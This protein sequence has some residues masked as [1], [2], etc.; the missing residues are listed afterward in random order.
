VRSRAQKLKAL[1]AFT[2]LALH[3]VSHAALAQPAQTTP[4]E[5]EMKRALDQVRKDPNLGVSTEIRKLKWAGQNQPRP[6]RD[7]SAFRWLTELARWIA[8]TSRILIYV[9]AGLAVIAL[10]L[11]ITRFLGEREP[12]AAKRRVILPTHVR[13]LDIRPESLPDNI[14]SAARELWDRNEHRAALSLLYRGLLSRL[15]HAHAVPIRAATTEGD[16][17]MLARKHLPADRAAYVV[18]LVKV[19]QRAVYGGHDPET[20][21]VIELCDAFAPALDPTA[22]RP[23]QVQP[24]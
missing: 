24:A 9:L 4:T 1:A 23:L 15:A 20:A 6:K 2:V 13:D 10:A 18:S 12:R 11:Y 14:G 22:P 19:W 5:I 3:G 16:C 8:E 7:L 17:L 21:T